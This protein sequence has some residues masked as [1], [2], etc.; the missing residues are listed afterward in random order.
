MTTRMDRPPVDP[1]DLVVS[2]IGTVLPPRPSAAGEWFDHRVELAPRGYKYVPR[3]AQYLLAAG[4]RALS[5][6]GLDLDEDRAARCGVALG[7]NGCASALH[8]EIDRTMLG[9]GGLGALQPATAPYF[10]VNLFLSR[11]TI[12][13][14]TTAFSLALHTPRTAGLE[15]VQA[16]R[17]AVLAGRAG[18]LVVGA[19]EQPLD[20]VEPAA[21]A[22]E[23]GAV[24]L[25]LEPAA[26]VL[27]RGGRA[28]GRCGAVS[29]F[30]PPAATGTAPGRTAAAA[31]VLA[32]L[33]ALGLTGDRPLPPVRLVR[34]DSAVSAA[35]AAALRPVGTE[36]SEVDAGPG[37]LGPLVEVAAALGGDRETLVVAA[38]ATGTVAAAL[39]RPGPA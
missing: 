33:T 34:D 39:V 9:G 29:F 36:L 16:G 8:G 37:C 25:V 15:A 4:K 35:V 38:T 28:H 26:E 30:L 11:L 6:A 18:W 32:R 20:A 12:E 10:S 17:R 3:S 27:A 24:V 14:H 2:G 7:S 19:T 22:S 1:V 13:L 31:T 5:D 21:A 23:D